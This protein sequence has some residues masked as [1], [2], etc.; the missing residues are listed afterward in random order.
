[1]TKRFYVDLSDKQISMAKKMRRENPPQPWQAVG[2]ACGCSAD[3]IRRRLDPKWREMK[4]ESLRR[5]RARRLAAGQNIVQPKTHPVRQQ[6]EK[7]LA[8]I[9]EDTRSLTARL[10]GDPLPGRSALDRKMMEDA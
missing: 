5:S 9:P 2:K 7:L 6:A 8:Q 4:A 1:M 3:T 10:A